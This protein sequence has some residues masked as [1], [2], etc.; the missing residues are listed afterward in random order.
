MHVKLH[1]SHK[2]TK[3]WKNG[4][5]FGC[6]YFSFW[7][8]GY[9]TQ[10][11]EALETRNHNTYMYTHHPDAQPQNKLKCYHHSNIMHIYEQL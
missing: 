5:F 4:G 6:Y 1:I 10:R 7:G 3:K 9:S 2:V 8:R 11:R